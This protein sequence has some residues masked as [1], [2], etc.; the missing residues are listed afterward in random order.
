MYKYKVL[1][2]TATVMLGMAVAAPSTSWAQRVPADYGIVADLL[3][4]LGEGR[5][6]TQEETDACW[7]TGCSNGGCLQWVECSVWFGRPH[8]L[9]QCIRCDQQ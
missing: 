4:D 9:I 6:C 8:C 1:C 5:Q 2:L 7:S 3:G